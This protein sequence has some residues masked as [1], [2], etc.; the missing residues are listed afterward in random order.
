VGEKQGEIVMRLALVTATVAALAGIASAAPSFVFEQRASNPNAPAGTTTYLL[1]YNDTAIPTGTALPVIDQVDLTIASPN[2]GIRYAF[3]EE[4]GVNNPFPLPGNPTQTARTNPPGTFFSLNN[5]TLAVA[6][7]SATEE[8]PVT[9]NFAKYV[10]LG[11]Q[12]FA[13]TL[14]NYIFGGV[15][16]ADG[17]SGT[18]TGRVQVDGTFVP[19]SAAWGNVL[20]PENVAPAFVGAPYELV[21]DFGNQQ[22]ATG[23]VAGSATDADAGDIVTISGGALPP[24]LAGLTFSSVAGNPGTFTLSGTI[25]SLNG[26]SFGDTF[27]IPLTAADNNATSG[28]AAS[29]ITVRIV[30]EP[31]TLGL[32]AGAGLLALRRRK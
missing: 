32:L 29:S 22:F 2:G 14:R 6:T 18:V 26:A 16:V 11:S 3:D 13:A 19:F 23:S 27:V 24:E 8:V 7:G 20:P 4:A 17:S 25:D 21:L 10:V 28:N 15:V 5:A 30:P 12:P 31:A 1:R 9:P